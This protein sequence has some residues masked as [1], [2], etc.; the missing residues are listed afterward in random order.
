MAHAL[1]SL[2]GAKHPIVQAPIGSF[3]S[4]KLVSAAANAGCVGMFA[5]S[6]TGP[7]KISAII[8]KT[9]ALTDGIYGINLV[10]EWDQTERLEAALDAGCRLVSFFWGD[11][12]PYI[13]IAKCRGAMVMV[14]VGSAAE[15][16]AAIDAGADI[17][18]AQGWEAGG[19][20][21]GKVG[22]MA[23]IPAI[24]QMLPNSPLIAAGG[25]ASGQAMVAARALG[26]DGV[27]MGTRFVASQEAH[28]HPEFKD[29]LVAAQ[30]SMTVIGET[31]DGGWP[32]A[33]HRV[34]RNATTDRSPCS[35]KSRDVIATLA[36]GRPVHRYDQIPP[37]KGIT[38]S[39]Q[40][41]ALY[42]GQSVGQVDEILSV[43]DIVA[44]I[45]REAEETIT[46]LSSNRE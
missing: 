7:E 16:Q 40:D 31:F 23:L 26:A 25:I 46:T 20:V 21:W 29:M 11:A 17:L 45:L 32:N 1:N 22:T 5:M 2:I 44:Q 27:W 14:T 15:A 38:G 33:A 12:A 36:N 24:R 39:W 43:A 8:E 3:S 34:L 6:W 9:N 28:A 13:E 30:E 37:T 41:T 42:A 19:H 4:P 18:V 35:E 10:L